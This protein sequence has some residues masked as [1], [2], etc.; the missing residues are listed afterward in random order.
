M[1]NTTTRDRLNFRLCRQHK[2]LIERAA[3]TLGQSITEFAVGSLVRDAHA[4]LRQ[5]E[6]T[7]LSDRDRRAFLSMLEGKAEPN[8]ALQTAARLYR[9]QRA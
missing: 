9:R 5:Q 6:T 7:V 3:M 2:A 1:P 4:V 8:A